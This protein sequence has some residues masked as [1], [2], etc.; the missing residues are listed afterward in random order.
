[1]INANT[2]DLAR[3]MTIEQGKPFPEA[4]V[5]SPMAPPLSN[6]SPSKPSA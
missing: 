1:L 6:G 2:D 4:K 3:I 5:K